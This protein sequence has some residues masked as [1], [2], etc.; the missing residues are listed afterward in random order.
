MRWELC[1]EQGVKRQVHPACRLVSSDIRIQLDA[2]LRGLGIALLPSV[3][4]FSDYLVV[5][6]ATSIFGNYGET[7]QFRSDV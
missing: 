3:R 1:D 7:G 6:L 5:H 4:S 2:A